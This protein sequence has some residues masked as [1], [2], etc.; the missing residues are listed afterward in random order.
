[1]TV[2]EDIQPEHEE[3]NDNEVKIE[4]VNNP[5]LQIVQTEPDLFEDEHVH[6]CA[7]AGLPEST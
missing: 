1:L 6:R 5:E 7:D 3:Q 4:E 2:S